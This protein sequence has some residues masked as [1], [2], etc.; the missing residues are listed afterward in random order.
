MAKMRTTSGLAKRK[1]SSVSQLVSGGQFIEEN[2][3]I[4]EQ[5]QLS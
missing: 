5:T 4:A 3:T 1:I 2:K